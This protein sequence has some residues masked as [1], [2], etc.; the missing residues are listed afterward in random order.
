MYSVERSQMRIV[1]R[2]SEMLPVKPVQA[3]Q[4]KRYFT[5]TKTRGASNGINGYIFLND[6]QPGKAVFIDDMQLFRLK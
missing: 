5:F 4:W 3:G 2:S 1:A 6:F